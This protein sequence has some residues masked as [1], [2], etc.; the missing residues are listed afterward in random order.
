VGE[1]HPFLEVEVGLE[2]L[3][4]VVVE[5]PFLVVEVVLVEVEVVVLIKGYIEAL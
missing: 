5:V 4:V 2:D 3:L 1:H